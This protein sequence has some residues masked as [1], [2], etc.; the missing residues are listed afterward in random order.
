M[1]L[2][3]KLGKTDFTVVVFVQDSSSTTGAGLAGIAAADVNAR[4]IRVE[5]D[6]DV[7]I[8]QITLSDLSA[9]TDAHADG[10]WFP[11]DATN[12]PGWYRLDLPD[13]TFA[14]GAWSAGVSLIDAG[15]NDIAPL[16]LEFQLVAYDPLDTVRLG[17]TALPNAAA[18]AAGGLIISD[19][20][21]LDADAQRSDVAAI[22]VDTGTTLQGELDGI[23]ADTE[24]IQ[25]RLPAALVGGR[26]DATIDNTGLEAGALALINAEVV[27]ALATDTYAEP[28]GVPSSTDDLATK[29]GRIYQALIEKATATASAKTFHDNAGNALWKKNVSDDGTTYQETQA[30][31]P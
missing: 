10:G 9:L 31:S 18:D 5:T 1:K 3:V 30:A 20:G 4:L 6:N 27:D 12:A 22:L 26:I 17:L 28:S 25:T 24:D 16:A 23:Q 2:Q 29:I 15:A 21:G 8:A 19:A 11:V 14:S 13:S 7:T